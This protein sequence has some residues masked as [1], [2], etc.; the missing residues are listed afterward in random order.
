M[1]SVE[2]EDMIIQKLYIMCSFLEQSELEQLLSS[3][4]FKTFGF[5]AL[6]SGLPCISEEL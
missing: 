3:L 2:L 1:S 4:L 6:F 5:Y